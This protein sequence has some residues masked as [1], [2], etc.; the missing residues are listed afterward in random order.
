[1]YDVI[2]IG[3][4]TYDV[5]LRSELF[6]TIKDPHFNKKMGFPTGKAE[7]FAFGGKIDVEE[8]VMVS[9]GGATNAA[10]TFARQGLKTGA[11]Y[12]VGKDVFGDLVNKELIKEKVKVLGT[13]DKK[14]KTG[15]STLLLAP[16][17]E[18]SILVYRGA[19][20]C[21]ATKDTPLSKMKSSWFYI[22]PS[23]ID[24]KVMR[25]MVDYA[26]K[27]NILVAMNPSKF[28]VQ[29][30]WT[31]L[32]SL[33]KKIAVLIMNREE[34]A[35]LTGV[36]YEKRDDIFDK[37]LQLRRGQGITVMTDGPDGVW[38]TDGKSVYRAG[39]FKENQLVDRTGAGDG[40][41]SGFV[42]GL[43]LGGK[44]NKKGVDQGG[45]IK[46]AIRLAS[47]NATAVVEQVGAKAGI[48]TKTDF[49]KKRWRGLDIKVSNYA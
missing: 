17:G 34:A 28:Y 8:P 47:A 15:Y 19:A 39:I 31:V 13:A 45:V 7:C 2:T 3:T 23:T 25:A 26:W 22:V 16:E 12:R 38:V 1:M 37:L 6:K 46:E 4:A 14:L 20:C 42:A 9:G 5:F 43:I 10:V 11:V 41:G 24:L 21:L 35:Y 29:A 18:R 48:L 30:G 36:D 40:F 49:F 44:K 32:E 33:M 27:N